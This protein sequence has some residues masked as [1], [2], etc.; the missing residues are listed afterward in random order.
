M[1]NHIVSKKMAVSTKPSSSWV[2]TILVFASLPAYLMAATFHLPRLNPQEPQ[3]RAP[4]HSQPQYHAQNGARNIMHSFKNDKRFF[5]HGEINVIPNVQHKER[6]DFGTKTSGIREKYSSATV[7]A[8]VGR[9]G[10]FSSKEKAN[11]QLNQN[12]TTDGATLLQ[13]VIRNARAI[14]VYNTSYVNPAK[15][16]K[17]NLCLVDCFQFNHDNFRQLFCDTPV[18]QRELKT[19]LISQLCEEDLFTFVGDMGLT[20]QEFNSAQSRCCHSVRHVQCDKDTWGGLLLYMF[21][22]VYYSRR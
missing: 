13:N 2:V 17:Q 7:T 16:F 8:S 21:K 12:K 14:D 11:R 4:P 10:K 9:W 22:F 5:S 15:C 20:Q 19:F 6:S 18:G 1:N 3:L